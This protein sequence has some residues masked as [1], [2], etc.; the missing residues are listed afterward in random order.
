[1]NE[2]VWVAERPRLLTLGYRMLGSWQD[3][4]DVLQDAWLRWSAADVATV[5]SPA[6][7]LTTIVTRLAIDRLRVRQR[8]QETYV[9]PWLPEPIATDRLP[10]ELATDAESLSLATLHLMERLSP[11][12]RAVYVLR[13]GFG[14]S[15]KQIGAILDRTE[16]AARQL[17]HRSQQRIGDPVRFRAEPDEHER[18]L[19]AVLGAAREGA[20]A[21]LERV[22]HEQV[23]L[24]SDG[25]GKVKTA[26]NLVVG[27]SRVAR[28]LAGVYGRI[29]ADVPRFIDVNGLPAVD[30]GRGSGRRIITLEIEDGAVTAILMVGNPDKLTMV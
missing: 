19:R 3:A 24:W 18:L 1:M 4:E 29:V 6:A 28:F 12:E 17:F 16:P 11:P 27:S 2:S 15:F 25:G 13:E 23:V 8:A 14:Y 7:Y 20:V 10:E 26:R 5:E 30:I 9:G 22:L 21:D